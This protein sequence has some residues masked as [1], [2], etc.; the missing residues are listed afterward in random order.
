M[1][2]KQL[3]LIVPKVETCVKNYV[4]FRDATEAYN[5]TRSAH[6][7]SLNDLVNMLLECDVVDGDAELIINACITAGMEETRTLKAQVYE[8]MR[9]ALVFSNPNT[10]AATKD[11]IK[12]AANKTKGYTQKRV[13]TVIQSTKL[14]N[15][16]YMNAAKAAQK[17]RI[18]DG[19]GMVVLNEVLDN[20][21]LHTLEELFSYLATD[22]VDWANKAYGAK[23]A[24]KN[25]GNAKAS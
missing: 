7:T 5:K 9:Q 21:K 12:K 19:A 20:P 16:G 24:Q 18:W 11:V 1:N 13:K 14:V 25:G 17:K 8:A 3:G 2:V 22:F 23:L 4:A 6:A 15:A 10:P